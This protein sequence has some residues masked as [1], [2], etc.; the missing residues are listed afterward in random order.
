MNLADLDASAG[1][2]PLT[3]MLFF[4]AVIGVGCVVMG[5]LHDEPAPVLGGVLVV[6]AFGF[7]AFDT[8]LDDYYEAKTQVFAPKLK[9]EFGLEATTGLRD[10]VD[11]AEKGETVPMTRGDQL[12]DVRPVIEDDFL[13]LFRASDGQMLIPE[14]QPHSR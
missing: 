13:K 3:V 11:A 6:C 2:S 7:L 9:E 14:P 1:L 10:I 4:A 12:I 8:A 5:F